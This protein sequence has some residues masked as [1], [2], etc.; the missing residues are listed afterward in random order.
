MKNNDLMDKVESA[1]PVRPGAFQN[2]SGTT[3]G[4][5]LLE[6]IVEVVPQRTKAEGV[7][8]LDSRV[9]ESAGRRGSRSFVAG[10]VA[11]A[12][13]LGVSTVVSRPNPDS[14][15]ST[16]WAASLIK[17]AKGSPRLLVTADGWEVVR[18]R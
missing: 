5:D 11:V 15:T 13:I 2:L 7:S 9:T 1:N 3:E 10:A 14:D 17:L 18:A 16:A 12:L 4:R 8:T 6:R